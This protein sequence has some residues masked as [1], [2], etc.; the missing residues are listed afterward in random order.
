MYNLPKKFLSASQ[1]NKYLTCPKQYEFEYVLQEPTNFKRSV[2]LVTGSSVHKYVET[3]IKRMLAAELQPQSYSEVLVEADAEIKDM[4]SDS[5]VDLEEGT[6]ESGLIYSQNLYRLW[7]KELSPTILPLKSEYKFE[8]KVG[9]VP[10]L[11]FIDYVDAG[12]GKQE[13]C[14]LKVVDKS[15]SISDARDSVQ[16]AMYAIVE[17][18]PCVRFDSIVKTKTPKISQ[19]RYEYTKGELNYYTDLIGEVATSISAGNF[20]KTAPTSWACN[21]KWCPFYDK[22][23]GSYDNGKE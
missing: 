16:L 11:G 14:D 21:A 7:H 12:S 2:A 4:F 19:V 9:D 17:N 8:D 6:V 15:K 10:V 23:R 5:S 1:I 13:I 22:C 18:N 3:H 20:P